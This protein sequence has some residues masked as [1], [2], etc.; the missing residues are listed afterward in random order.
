MGSIPLPNSTPLTLV[1]ATEIKIG[2]KTIK[3]KIKVVR[4]SSQSLPGNGL[5]SLY[6]SVRWK[7]KKILKKTT[8]EKTNLFGYRFMERI[9]VSLQSRA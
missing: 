2:K 1:I 3:T 7:I 5:T 4:Q 9:S 8:K 6:G